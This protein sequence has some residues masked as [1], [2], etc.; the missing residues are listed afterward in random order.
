MESKEGSVQVC[1]LY[2]ILK[3][4]RGV[5]LVQGP[6]EGWRRVGGRQESRPQR[7]HVSRPRVGWGAHVGEE[8]PLLATG[9]GELGWLWRSVR[10]GEGCF[11]GSLNNNQISWDLGEK[12]WQI[13]AIIRIMLG[14]AVRIQFPNLASSSPFTSSGC[15]KFSNSHSIWR[16]WRR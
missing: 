1:R 10:V 9:G 15:P 5:G 7:E 11:L 16:V 13:N 14:F 4:R 6:E 12:I 8:G 3:E 2:W